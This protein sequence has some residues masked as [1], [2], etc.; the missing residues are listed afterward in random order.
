M[1]NT[2]MKPFPG[3]SFG[4]PVIGIQTG[5]A[6]LGFGFDHSDHTLTLT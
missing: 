6:P 1:C 2:Q 3:S 4:K 5:P